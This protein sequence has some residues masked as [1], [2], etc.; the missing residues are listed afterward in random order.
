[1]APRLRDVQRREMIV[2]ETPSIPINVQTVHDNV[3]RDL[4]E[5]GFELHFG[6]GACEET[7][8]WRWSNGTARLPSC[9]GRSEVFSQQP[10]ERACK[11]SRTD[12]VP[13]SF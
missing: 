5:A 10:R 1:M 13:L 9:F 6:Q 4:V 8:E 7:K 12:L 2:R 11:R 3:A